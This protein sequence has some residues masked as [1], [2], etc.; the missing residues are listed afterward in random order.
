MATQFK[1]RLRLLGW[2]LAMLPLSVAS[3]V[4]F[5]FTVVGAALV[6]VWVGVPMLLATIAL[7]RPL[8]NLHR[9]WAGA[10][11]GRAIDVP[12]LA[13]APGGWLGRL[14]GEVLD[15]ASRRDVLWLAANGTVGMALCIVGIVESIFDLIFWWLPT[16]LSV[17]L[18]AGMC[19]ALL[20]TS[21][22][23]RLALRVQQLS[24]SRA[25]TVDTQAA[26]LRRIE[27]DLHDGA[28]A[29]LVAIGMSLGMAEEQLANDPELA[30]TLLLEARDTASDAL[31][32][33]RD[34]VRGIHPPVLAERGF[35]E[36]VR[37][38]AAAMPVP[39]EISAD[40]AGRLPA[41]VESAAYFAVAEALA[42]VV[43]H[44][45]AQHVSIAL[46][47]SDGALRMT[48][49][50]DGRG[51]ADAQHGTGL[52]GI[53][54]RLG[55]FDGTLN[56]ESPTGGPTKLVMVLPCQPSASS[57]ERTSPSSGTA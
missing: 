48:V 39:V 29:R 42:N 30:R 16:A 3:L 9:R 25:E 22:K 5:V 50:D 51:G 26:E 53:E 32:E 6:T 43:K 33:L 27:R 34:L 1:H 19:A 15:P 2:A 55:A 56:V 35:V 13:P 20:A 24:T 4:L 18:H 28:Q 40:I 41:P 17:R 23:S 21:E 52:R 57:S 46:A 38:L 49:A 36:A 37:A 7:T 11:T 12:Y 47:Y 54:R 10:F 31:A 44:A 8:A 45:A 14:R